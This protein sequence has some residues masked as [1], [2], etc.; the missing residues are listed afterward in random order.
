MSGRP[1]PPPTPLGVLITPDTKALSLRQAARVLGAAHSTLLR[2]LRAAPQNAQ[3]R[4]IDGEYRG[5][6][7]RGVHWRVPIA[8]LERLQAAQQRERPGA[9]GRGAL[10]SPDAQEVVAVLK[11]Y[12][13]E[14]I[15]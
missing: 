11:A 2:R 6:Y 12:L 7:R 14:Q 10:R 15:K 1:L 5:C 3:G 4:V 13:D 8:T 9:S